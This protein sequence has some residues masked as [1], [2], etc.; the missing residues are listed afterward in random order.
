MS[1]RVNNALGGGCD[2]IVICTVEIACRVRRT[3]TATSKIFPLT[4]LYQHSHYIFASSSRIINTRYTVTI[5]LFRTLL[6]NGLA[7]TALAYDK[8]DKRA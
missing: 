6:L 1:K 8:P 4:L 5:A 3:R 7:N 2:V